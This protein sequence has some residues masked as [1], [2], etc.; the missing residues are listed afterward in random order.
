MV[1]GVVELM[2][3]IET[4][5]NTGKKGAPRVNSVKAFQ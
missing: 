4:K 2:G 1:S 5:S 3:L